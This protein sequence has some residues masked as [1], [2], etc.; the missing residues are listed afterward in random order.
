MSEIKVLIN[1]G[2]H[3]IFPINWSRF[4]EFGLP[5][6]KNTGG[7]L[8]LETSIRSYRI[9]TYKLC[10]ALCKYGKYMYIKLVLHNPELDFEWGIPG[11]PH[12]IETEITL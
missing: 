11:G 5:F 4:I 2:G 6:G 1:S 3:M 12:Q 10:F 9:S 8:Q 7:L